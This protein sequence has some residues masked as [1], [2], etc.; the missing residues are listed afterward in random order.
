MTQLH[1]PMPS[2]APKAAQTGLLSEILCPN[3]WHKF[4]PEDLLFISRHDAMVG[5][6]IAGPVAYRRFLPS[7]FNIT[8]DALDPMG[9]VSQQIACPRCHLEIARPLIEMLPFFIS[10]VGAA[11]SGKS[12]LL[13][14]MI[15][16]LRSQA[17][18]LGF[19][20]TDGDPKA[21]YELQRYEEL[22]FMNAHPDRPVALRKTVRDG[23]EL[24]QTVTLDEQSQTFPKPFQ[25]TIAPV[26]HHPNAQQ[27][28]YRSMVLYDNAGEDFLPGEDK[29]NAPVTLHLAESAA[30]MFVFDPTQDARFRPLCNKN[31]PQLTSG[32]RNSKDHTLSRQEV[33][34][35][36]MVARIRKYKGLGQG[37]QHTRPLIMILA[38]ADTWL[39]IPEFT[40][41]PITNE[42]DAGLDLPAI[43]KV[44]D[45]VREVLKN[46]CPE[47]VH[48][49]EAFSSHVVYIPVS[50]LGCSPELVTSANDSFLGIRPQNI[51]PRW[52]TTP[53]LWALAKSVPGMV[54]LSIHNKADRA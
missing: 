34:F 2:R 16:Q 53:M 20:L 40:D 43:A 24:Y 9:V 54:P 22:L 32:I 13:A 28:P 14:S 7:R 27:F 46:R 41:E 35:N 51:K 38:K 25:F 49:A 6:D 44:S 21:N 37:E 10:I 19:T 18:R 12:Y 30:V 29:T 15:W 17:A 42:P 33:I 39:D 50:S 4:P 52:V 31:D 5:D 48:A 45:H 36:E 26:A 8:G 11:G 1:Q 47:I 3:C 23:H